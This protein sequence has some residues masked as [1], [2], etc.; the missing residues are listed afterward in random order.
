[1]QRRAIKITGIVQG[2]GFRP[3]VFSLASRLKLGGFV[4]NR[5]GE[6]RIEVEGHK[7]ALNRFTEHLRSGAP[8][9]SRIDS[10]SWHTIPTIH[11]CQ[12][13]IVESDGASSTNV[14]VSPDVATCADCRREL[15]DPSDR[16][17]R[18]PFSNCTNCGPRLTI[19]HRAPYDR[20]NTTMNSFSMC[21][22][23]RSEYEDPTDRRFHAQPIACPDCGPRLQL[24][25]ASG[26]VVDEGDCIDAF[27][28]LI[29]AGRIGALKGLGGYHLV[30]S[31]TDDAA[32]QSL[33]RRKRRDEKPFAVMVRDAEL[34]S[35]W[36]DIRDEERNLLASHRRP[37]VLLRKRADVAH[38][39][40]AVA[41]RN[42]FL[43]MMLP[44]T[45]LHELLIDQWGDEPLVM[46]SGNL[47]DE[48]M[49]HDDADA[50]ARLRRVADA[51]LVH[52]RPIHMRCD[53]SVTR[54][55]AGM[56]SPIRRSR[57][58][59]PMPIK[60]PFS[61]RKPCLA[62]G[63]QLKNVFALA[64][65]DNAFLSHHMGDLDHLAA[66]DALRRDIGLYEQLFGIKPGCIV[67]DMHPD[68]ASTTYAVERAQRDSISAIAVQ[69]HH[70]HLASC[71]VENGLNGDVIGVILDGSG[72]GT[73]GTIWGGEFL[74]GGYQSFETRRTPETGAT[75]GRRQGNEGTVAH[76]GQLFARRGV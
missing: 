40:D 62:V 72:Y 60:L 12:F 29:R 38:M 64:S 67:H 10:L 7:S 59:A 54:V 74:L 58:Y 14:F 25:D 22:R 46:T 48:P 16:R 9:L 37:I 65:G 61:C 32:V 49:A 11:D 13:H 2:V 8:P 73:D 36:C 66:F 56:E 24:L 41:P 20:V 31:A 52:D 27:C 63:G 3:F 42:P 6:V 30:C 44:Y 50:V 18:Y 5:S 15:F 71:M 33:R 35:R 34:A 39:S 1:M 45:P 53:D 28:T 75:T 17:Y 68:Y 57:G 69:H 55:I 23:C 47:S 4:Q 19:I 43:G 70:A 51:F 76:G 21:E 26:N